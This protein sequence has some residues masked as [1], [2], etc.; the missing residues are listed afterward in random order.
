MD[1][2]GGGQLRDASRFPG[3]LLGPSLLGVQRHPISGHFWRGYLGSRGRRD[4]EG[5]AER[6][7]A[8]GS[9]ATGCELDRIGGG[10]HESS[11]RQIPGDAE[12]VPALDFR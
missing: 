9:D 12:P 5:G 1:H 7:S 10:Y 11:A 4:A 8:I 6:R 3:G 2:A